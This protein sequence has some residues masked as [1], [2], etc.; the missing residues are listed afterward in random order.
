MLDSQEKCVSM[1]VLEKEGVREREKA[2]EETAG[3]EVREILS[4][5]V[6]VGLYCIQYICS[7][8]LALSHTHTLFF[9]LSHAHRQTHTHS[10]TV[11]FLSLCHVVSFPGNYDLWFRSYRKWDKWEKGTCMQTVSDSCPHRYSHTYTQQT[12]AHHL[13]HTNPQGRTNTCTLSSIHGW[14]A[15]LFSN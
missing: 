13:T 4:D 2:R 3:V 12:Q 14:G 7:E 15:W 9:S 5:C 10:H 8:C 6:Y 11:L 1:W